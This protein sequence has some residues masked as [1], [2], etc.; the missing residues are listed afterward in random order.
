MLWRFQQMCRERQFLERD[1]SPKTFPS[2][3]PCEFRFVLLHQRRP[4]QSLPPPNRRTAQLQHPVPSPLQSP[5]P[6]SELWPT[7]ISHTNDAER[8]IILQRSR[9]A[10]QLG[11]DNWIKPSWNKC[12]QQDQISQHVPNQTWVSCQNRCSEALLQLPTGR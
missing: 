1:P 6:S 2:H 10:H 12:L 11:E 4:A 5:G 7:N 9:Y 3:R 8:I